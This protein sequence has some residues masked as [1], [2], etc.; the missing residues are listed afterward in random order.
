[1]PADVRYAESAD[2]ASCRLHLGCGLLLA[3]CIQWPSLSHALVWTGL[4]LNTTFFSRL[5]LLE[6][7]A[8]CTVSGTFA[9]VPGMCAPCCG[10]FLLARLY[11]ESL[12]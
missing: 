2:D 1:M 3:S 6:S 11:E 4:A 8:L 7:F 5:S 10:V 9:V 12:L